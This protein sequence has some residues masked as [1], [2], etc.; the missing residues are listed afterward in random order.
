MNNVSATSILFCQQKPW[1][2][3]VA[4][5]WNCWKLGKKHQS[6][7][8]GERCCCAF[9]ADH[10]GEHR[11]H[12]WEMH[13]S[14]FVSISDALLSSSLHTIPL[15]CLISENRMDLS[16]QVGTVGDAMPS[17]VCVCP[18]HNQV[19]KTTNRYP[20][21]KLKIIFVSSDLFPVTQV[22]CWEK[23]SQER[24]VRHWNRLRREVVEWS[25]PPW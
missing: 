13:S 25:H 4:E 9:P 2:G 11:G 21:H 15:P 1:R 18:P 5:K 12:C 7:E 16:P 10:P 3:R 23:F 17:L 24:V 14:Q 19:W 20:F 8:M 6:T 22:E